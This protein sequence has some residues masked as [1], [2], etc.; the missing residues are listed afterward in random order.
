[1]W[2]SSVFKGGCWQGQV[3]EITFL[4]DWFHPDFFANTSCSEF[5][6]SV[7]KADVKTSRCAV[8]HGIHP[9]RTQSAPLYSWFSANPKI[10]LLLSTGLW[11]ADLKK[12]HLKEHPAF[13]VPG[14]QQQNP[15]NPASSSQISFEVIQTKNCPDL[16]PFWKILISSLQ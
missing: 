1:M 13:C 5:P 11:K 2:G 14:F 15:Q 6:K 8:V 3:S 10:H 4:M 7:K 16:S 9:S 12:V